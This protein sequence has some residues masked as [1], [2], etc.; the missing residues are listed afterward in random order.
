MES[1]ALSFEVYLASVCSVKLWFSSAIVLCLLTTPTEAQEAPSPETITA[2]FQERVEQYFRAESG[3]P[4]VR[5]K[6]RAP[7][8]PGRGNFARHYSYSI[9]AFAAR[10]LYL[11]EQLE[12][13]NAALAENA[14]H[15]L[16]NPL[17]IND[18]DSF[19]WHA[20]IVMR[21]I[22][23]YGSNGSAQPGRIT[24]ETEELA[25]RPIWFY[26]KGCSSLAKAEWRKSETWRL[27]SSENHHAMDFTVNWHFAKLAKDHPSYKDLKCDDGATL[28]EHYEAWSD[29]FVAYCVERAKKSP[30]VEMMSDH[31]NSALIKGFYN[32]YDFGDPR[33]K[34]SAGMLLD[35][36]WAYWAQEQIGGIQGGGSS[37][38]SFHEALQAHVEHGLASLAWLYFG[39]GEIPAVYGHDMNAALSSYSPP[40]VVADIAVD[41]VGRGRYEI[42]QRPQGLGRTSRADGSSFT[43]LRTDGGGILRYSYCDPSFIIGCPMTEARPLADWAAISSQGRWQGVVFSGDHDARIV[44]MARPQN[45]LRGFNAQWSVQS[46]GT[47]LT[48]KLKQNRGMA[49][50]IVWMT[51]AGLSDP[52]EIEDVVFVEAEGAYAA[53]R[54]VEG[55]FRWSEEIY[56]INKPEGIVYQTRP[57]NT[58]VLNNEYSPVILEVM[59]K[60]DV[61]DFEAFQDKVTST[62]PRMNGTIVEYDTIYGDQLTLDTHHQEGATINGML[63]NYSPQR[64]FESPFLNAD[65]NRGVIT[66]TKGKR[67][68]LLDFTQL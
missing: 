33:T 26:V 21:L 54:V 57:G 12:E 52:V 66:I 43:D 7:L 4:L 56:T 44:P 50:M 49:E 6:I 58:M 61:A 62:K 30:C 28:E 48:Q 20:D 40:V 68:K 3:E 51:K 36:F 17:D 46:K 19:H 13:A 10:C 9:V 29:Y 37:R 32:F 1:R 31:Y 14:Q 38:I 11:G 5:G 45:N 63:V 65:Y 34:Q 27:Y 42:R 35:L 25:L 67:Q 2:G 24:Q 15:Y 47:L 64:L 18:R 39:I 23:M 53:V 22:E 60:S 59:A 8:G 16:D 55:G 41:V